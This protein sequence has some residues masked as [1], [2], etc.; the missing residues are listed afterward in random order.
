M[1]QNQPY[2]TFAVVGFMLLHFLVSEVHT[3][4]T[5]PDCSVTACFNVFRAV[6]LGA[7]GFIAAGAL[8]D[9]SISCPNGETVNDHTRND[10]AALAMAAEA[11]NASPTAMAVVDAHRRIEQCNPAFVHLISQ[12]R[13]HHG[14]SPTAS[15]GAA[16][17]YERKTLDNTLGIFNHNDGCSKYTDC[18]FVVQD[19]IMRVH[20][21]SF[22]AMDKSCVGATS[23]C[24]EMPLFGLYTLTSKG[25]ES[26]RR[27]IV[28]LSDVTLERAIER[29]IDSKLLQFHG[30]NEALMRRIRSKLASTTVNAK[31]NT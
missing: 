17:V 24:R 6:V 30:D 28:V 4:V 21:V 29:A 18:E 25:K 16:T 20:V 9:G 15:I 19:R 8:R 27:F 22:M 2:L 12:V 11:Y 31:C 1:K 7:A 5:E 3:I 26:T 23:Q 13:R 10:A 14:L